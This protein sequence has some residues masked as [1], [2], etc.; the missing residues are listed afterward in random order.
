MVPISH[1]KVPFPIKLSNLSTRPA[2]I[3]PV[4]ST[5]PFCKLST[6]P[7]VIF[8]CRH[9]FSDSKLLI[10]RSCFP[11]S[12]IRSTSEIPCFQAFFVH[13]LLNF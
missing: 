6:Q 5:Y 11:V 1:Y 12:K 3:Q 2:N 8:L 10:S 13:L 9:V 7:S 4:Y